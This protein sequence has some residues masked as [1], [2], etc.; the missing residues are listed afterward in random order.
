MVKLEAILVA[1]EEAAES[2]G[3]MKLKNEQ[4]DALVAF[5]WRGFS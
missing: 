2:I 3:V 4:K 1:V 5:A